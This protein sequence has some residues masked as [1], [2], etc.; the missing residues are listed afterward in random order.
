MLIKSVLF[1][2]AIVVV[3]HI[4]VSYTGTYLLRNL[5]LSDSL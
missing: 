3:P 4:C 2:G 5:D 1:S